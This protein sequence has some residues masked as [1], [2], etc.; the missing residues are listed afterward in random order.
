VNILLTSVTADQVHAEVRVPNG[1]RLTAASKDISRVEEY[2]QWC[3]GLYADEKLNIHSHYSCYPLQ[4]IKLT[5]RSKRRQLNQSFGPN[6]RF[7]HY[8]NHPGQVLA[9]PLLHPNFT[10]QNTHITAY[11]LP[12]ASMFMQEWFGTKDSQNQIH[13]ALLYVA[14]QQA[15]L[16]LFENNHFLN[17]ATIAFR[18][19]EDILYH[20]LFSLDQFGIPVP[21]C[22]ALLVGPKADDSKLLE[23]FE[24][25]TA[26][27]NDI[28]TSADDR[29]YFD[30]KLL[31]KC[32]S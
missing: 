20:Y 12:L 11:Q 5:A 8:H 32:A 3:L 15:T 9:Y 6:L 16:C 14:N 19:A 13:T 21:S 1:H 17:Q 28:F 25:Q 23:L 30:L 22:A 26:F 27:E 24:N 2:K 4:A 7:Y 10:D 18:T 31:W 29:K